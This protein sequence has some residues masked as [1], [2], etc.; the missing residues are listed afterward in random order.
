[1]LVVTT[2]KPKSYET[3]AKRCIEGLV[4]F[5]PGRVVVY[6]EDPV[7]VDGAEVRDFWG[8]PGVKTFLE[9]IKRVPG[10]DGHGLSGFD[11]RFNCKAFCRKV[12]VQDAVFGEDD[13]VFWVD[14]DSIVKKPI[15]KEFLSELMDG[16]ALTFM[17]R[18]RT[19][20]ETGFVGFNTKHPDFETFRS[21]Y[22][23]WFTTGKVFQQLKG[24]HD[25]IAFDIARQGLSG[26]DLSPR[27]NGYDHVLHTTVLEPYLTHLK[28][29]RKH[30]D[31]LAA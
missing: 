4:E 23:S 6:A 16:V 2:F 8:I 7:S 18:R 12:F 27:G 28:G 19:Y 10:S 9:R 5:F 13:L 22:L 1:L 20:T 11:F 21:R 14:A 30:Q 29:A 25:C 26:R 17:G 15:P 24:W 31:V 3:Y